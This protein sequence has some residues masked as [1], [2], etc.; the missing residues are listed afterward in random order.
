MLPNNRK[1]ARFHTSLLEKLLDWNAVFRPVSS[2]TCRS[3][4]PY[5]NLETLEERTVPAAITWI[6]PGSG[7]WDAP[8]NRSTGSTYSIGASGTLTISSD[9]ITTTST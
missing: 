4:Q 2:R 9:A 7:N 6:N 5:W 1:R 3:Q 8:A